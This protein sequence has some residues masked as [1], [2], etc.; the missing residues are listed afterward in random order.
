MWG[1]DGPEPS[2]GGQFLLFAVR[3]LFWRGYSR[4]QHRLS[5]GVRI[6]L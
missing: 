2:A 1:Q 4:G 5:F 6:A 3:S